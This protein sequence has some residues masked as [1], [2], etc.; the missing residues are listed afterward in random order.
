MPA[1]ADRAF[2]FIFRRLWPWRLRCCYCSARRP[3]S[4]A[5]TNIEATALKLQGSRLPSFWLRLCCPFADRFVEKFFHLA[6]SFLR[7]FGL[8]VAEFAL[9]FTEFS[10]LLSER[11][12][13]FS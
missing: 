11:A 8:L 10:L 7:Q 6:R 5:L 9:L 1:Q 12:L 4:A 3:E 2:R 13:L